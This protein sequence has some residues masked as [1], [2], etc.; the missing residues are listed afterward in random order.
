MIASNPSATSRAP[1]FA[2]V[3]V[4]TAAVVAV[5]ANSFAGV[6]VFDDNA[7]IVDNQ[8][9]HRFEPLT[10]ARS[11]GSRPLLNLSL[12]AN[13]ALGG[14][15][16]FGYHLVNLAVHLVAVGLL[17]AVVRATLRSPRL[18]A[19]HGD[20]AD[21]LAFVAALLWAVHPLNTQA[22]TYIVQR[23]ESM[24]AAA[25][26]A[27][28]WFLARARVSPR[29]WVWRCGAAFA[30][31]VS[32]AS[33]EVG[34]MA[35]PVG[36]LYDWS[37]F[38]AVD[39]VAHPP[40]TWRRKCLA[41]IA[42]C[43]LLAAGIWWIKPV[44]LED[45]SAGFGTVAVTPGQYLRSQPGVIAHYLRLVAW[46]NPLCLDYGWPVENRWLVGVA[47]PA[48]G[49][50]G[51]LV[52]SVIL[53]W[54][55]SAVGFP[56][57]AFFL[58]LAPTSSIVPIQ[59]LAFEHRMY[60]PTALVI[61]T[62][63]IALHTGIRRWAA[64]STATPDDDRPSAALS[65]SIVIA[66][67]IA[68]LAVAATLGLATVQRN[69]DYY[70]AAG[71]WRDVLVKVLKRGRPATNL[72]RVTANLGL[73]LHKAGRTDEALE[74]FE[75][76]LR[77]APQAAVIHANYA[78]AL[79]DL[80]RFEEAAN[81]LAQVLNVEP[82]SPHFVHQAALVAVRAGRMDEAEVLFRR[83]IESEPRTA[84]FRVNLAR[85]LEERKRPDEAIDQL[86]VAVELYGT[87]D[88]PRKEIERR[89]TRIQA[90]VHYE[91]GN[92]YRRQGDPQSARAE[93]ERAVTFDSTLAQAHNNLG[94]L[95]MSES[96]VEAARHFANAVEHAP[97][98]VEARFNLAQSLLRLGQINSAIEHLRL[99]VAARPD[100]VPA[101]E[102]LQRIEA[103]RRGGNSKKDR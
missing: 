40:L 43:G 78:Q 36:W 25:F 79:I 75:E 87:S 49:V 55:R 98:Y 57:L 70:S 99:I 15:D 2:R 52:A 45:G 27:V 88:P 18:K 71:M 19:V 86:K 42:T 22:V 74:V 26:L 66:I 67:S 65:N 54:R 103:I 101:Q 31:A 72:H 17:F 10:L 82:R 89:L 50:G 20:F 23:C 4:L 84:T 9:I 28:I 93:Y 47:L 97:D 12:A 39:G 91:R 48:V 41:V 60:L 68:F 96:P 3:A 92:E 7:L 8:A 37:Y 83:A 73:E 29:P 100:F 46:P 77:I 30:L 61:A 32:V 90:R 44:L 95:A 5:Y 14:L 58:I 59:D 85:L 94:G 38:R 35:I 64:T 24:M 80:E 13:Y 33:K 34:L 6:F 63:V 51:L 11:S 62:A 76:G 1:L 56:A 102:S 81:H 21:N 53:A 69:R 16:P